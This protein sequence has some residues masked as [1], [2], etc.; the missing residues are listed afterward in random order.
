[1]TLDT[2][3]WKARLREYL[4]ERDREAVDRFKSPPDRVHS[5]ALLSVIGEK[6]SSLSYGIIRAVMVDMGWAPSP[7]IKIGGVQGRGFRRDRL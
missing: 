2:T 1:M 7:N 5:A 3:K 6:P 4:D